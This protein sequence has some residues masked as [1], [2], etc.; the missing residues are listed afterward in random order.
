V[1]ERRRGRGV[2]KER[3]KKATEKK[4]EEAVLPGMA[5][6]PV[7]GAEK[8]RARG[9]RTDGSSDAKKGVPK[10]TGCGEL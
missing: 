6:Q 2:D 8:Y 4:E 1:R 3:G 10:W 9:E 7:S 5:S